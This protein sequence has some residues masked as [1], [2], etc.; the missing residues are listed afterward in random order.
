LASPETAA[1]RQDLAK[2]SAR[3][4]QDRVIRYLADARLRRQP[5]SSLPLTPAEAEKAERFAR[6]L[7]RRYYR[8]RLLR[9]FRYARQLAP[10]TGRLADDIVDGEM[11]SRLLESGVLG[12]VETAEHVA[13]QAVNHLS[14]APSPGDW[15]PE[16]LQYESIFFVQLATSDHA[17]ASSLPQ[18]GISAV[19]KRFTWDLSEVLSRLKSGEPF[20]DE[21]RRQV[22]LL[23]SRTR[24]GRIFVMEVEAAVAAV[25]Q[26][27]DGRRT[28]E[29]IAVAASLPPEQ[30]KQILDSLVEIGAVIF[31]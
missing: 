19:L 29:Q 21:L 18:R 14:G 22:T 6:F 10:Q 2:M 1:N 26:A 24:E 17:R 3:E 16:L 8:D 15:W 31:S 12:S 9:A 20:A 25:F 7:A 5:V 11:F 30:T 13:E 28:V 4:L 27:T 23:F